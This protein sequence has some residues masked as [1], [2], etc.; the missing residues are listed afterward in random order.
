MALR[1][2][3]PAPWHVTCLSSRYRYLTTRRNIKWSDLVL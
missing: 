3:V 2:A 1:S